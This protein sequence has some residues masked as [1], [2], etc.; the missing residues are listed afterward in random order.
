MNIPESKLKQAG[1]AQGRSAARVASFWSM[2]QAA[3]REWT[4]EWPG[5]PSPET[6]DADSRL[7]DLSILLGLL[8]EAQAPRW[9]VDEVRR[10]R[11]TYEA[12]ERMADEV[13]E[14][15]LFNADSESDED[16]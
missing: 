11:R 15:E 2:R 7:L 10:L 3:I 12:D 16:E 8:R 13:D 6:S 5:F 9:L 4:R 14:L 1:E